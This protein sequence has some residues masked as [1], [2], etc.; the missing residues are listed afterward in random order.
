MVEHKRSMPYDS[1]MIHTRT[2]VRL[3]FFL[4]II[5]VL[6]AI[7]LR[8]DWSR[9]SAGIAI[10]PVFSDP[11]RLL[12][13][14][15]SLLC[16]IMVF[17]TGGDHVNAHDNRLMKII[18]AGIFSGDM[19]LLFNINGAGIVLFFLVQ[20]LLCVRHMSGFGKWLRNR[21]GRRP[22]RTLIL[23]TVSVS[24]SVM[25]LHYLI[26]HPL[27][28]GKDMYPLIIAYSS[29]LGLSL[30]SALCVPF[31]GKFHP[32]NGIVIAVGMTMFFLCDCTV[33]VR[34]A[35]DDPMVRTFAT[36]LTWVFYMPALVL[37]AL[38]GYDLKRLFRPGR[39]M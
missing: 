16:L 15:V 30:L 1:R 5:A 29:V 11:S 2:V 35:A 31:V 32:V 22:A 20:I 27:F 9:F 18:F 21:E 33:G 36:S 39:E 7:F 10:Y 37:L 26:F 34:M 12:K 38:S 6:S 23:I 3:S 19:L 4:V 24:A 17:T 14:A 13:R 8:L 25:I 28:S